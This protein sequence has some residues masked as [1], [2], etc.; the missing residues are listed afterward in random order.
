MT[1]PPKRAVRGVT[2]PCEEVSANHIAQLAVLVEAATA[3]A[4]LAA[5][6]MH[7]QAKRTRILQDGAKAAREGDT[8]RCDRRKHQYTQ[9]SIQVVDYTDAH[10][11]LIKAVIPLVSAEKRKELKAMIAYKWRTDPEAL[12]EALEDVGEVTPCD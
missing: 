8:E 10:L 4:D 12:I 7:H 3:Y 5:R 2:G 6:D 11:N 1:A 9:M